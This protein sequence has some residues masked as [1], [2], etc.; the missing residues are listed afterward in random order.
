MKG[1]YDRDDTRSQHLGAMFIYGS[2]FGSLNLRSADKC[3]KES[4]IDDGIYY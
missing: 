4:I 3:G 2:I 1:G